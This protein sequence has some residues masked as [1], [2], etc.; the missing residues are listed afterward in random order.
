MRFIR[1]CGDCVSRSS[2]VEA[3]AGHPREQVTLD[4]VR[5]EQI[6][7]ELHF[8][9]EPTNSIRSITCMPSARVMG[10]VGWRKGQNGEYSHGK[11]GR[12]LVAVE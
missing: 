8:S 12:V 7:W 5:Q 10:L 3:T 2:H 1:S 11:K 4:G 6:L 9:Y